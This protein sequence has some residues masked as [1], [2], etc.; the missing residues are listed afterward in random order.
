MAKAALIVS[1]N[2]APPQPNV[3]ALARQYGVD[4]RTIRRWRAKGWAPVIPDAIRIL[5][6]DQSVP[7]AAQG[8]G[9][10]LAALL[11]IVAIGI[12]ILALAINGQTGWHFGTTPLAA[13]TFAAM[14][15]AGDLLAIVLLS[16]AG[17]LWRTRHR[18]MGSDAAFTRHRA[19]PPGGGER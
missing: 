16:A 1:P 18:L 4:R 8:S 15:V 17:L 6:Q 3:S 14:A 11:I 13:V 7:T 12:A 2:T 10:T 9:R 5:P 19:P